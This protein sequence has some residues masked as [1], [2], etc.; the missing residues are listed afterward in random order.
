MALDTDRL[1]LLPFTPGHLRTLI[2]A[3]ER[4]AER[5]GHP[6][7]DGLQ[8][9]FTSGDVSPVW[10]AQLR[11]AQDADPWVHGFAAVHRERGAVVGT[12]SFKGPPDADG[13]VEIAYGIA[14]GYQGQ[15]Y[16]T[17]VARAL[18]AVAAADARV[19]LVRAHTLPQPGPS[20]RVL[21]RCGFAFAGTVDDPEDGPV[22]RWERAPGA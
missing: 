8:E 18:L 15:G 12:G 10:L 7:A 3:P 22:W 14:P 11:E 5:F 21:E 4:F 19:R 17:E 20:P 2:E 6:L 13:A 1:R 16:A 9:F